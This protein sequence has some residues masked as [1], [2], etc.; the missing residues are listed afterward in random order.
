MTEA[1]TSLGMKATEMTTVI[2]HHT[3]VAVAMPRGEFAHPL[4]RSEYITRV[5]GSI[6]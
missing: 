1:T 5:I 6:G 2:E 4:A 3:C